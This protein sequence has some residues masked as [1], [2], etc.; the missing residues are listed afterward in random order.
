[1][2]RPGIDRRC[3]RGGLRRGDP[4]QPRGGLRSGARERPRLRAHGPRAPRATRRSLR[5][6]RARV[7]RLLRSL[8]YVAGIAIVLALPRFIYPVLALDILLWGL[9]AVSVDLLLGFG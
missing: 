4:G 9:F 3:G 8:P 7:S 1:H 5:R 6:G 2:R